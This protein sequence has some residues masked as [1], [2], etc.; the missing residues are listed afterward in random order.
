LIVNYVATAPQTYLVAVSTT[1]PFQPY[2]I[3]FLLSRGTPCDDDRY[4]PNDTPAQATSVNTASSLEGA[5]CPQ[6]KDHFKIAVPAGKTLKVS[7]VNYDASRGLLELCLLNSGATV[8]FVCSQDLMPTAS[9]A[10]PDAGS[11]NV[12]ARVAGTQDRTANTYTLK[13]EFL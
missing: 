1:D 10:G 8:P 2:D 6:D 11:I 12:V 13:V 9:A 3:S 5:I 4:E 7:L